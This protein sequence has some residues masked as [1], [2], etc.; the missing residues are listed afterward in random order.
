M[1]GVPTIPGLLTWQFYFVTV[2]RR[3]CI[4]GLA[5][6]CG[7]ARMPVDFVRPLYS[8]RVFLSS[9]RGVRGWGN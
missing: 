9:P 6:V 4:R 3:V 7:I 1:G 5:G 8:D 2:F